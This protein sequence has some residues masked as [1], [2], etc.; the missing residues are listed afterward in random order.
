MYF[1]SDTVP[2]RILELTSVLGFACEDDASH[3]QVCFEFKL[4]RIVVNCRYFVFL[5]KRAGRDGFESK[6]VVLK[7]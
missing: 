1:F 3:L 5:A 6:L 7:E 4:I 2:K